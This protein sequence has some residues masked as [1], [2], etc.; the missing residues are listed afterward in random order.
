[1][2]RIL[3]IAFFSLILVSCNR[4]PSNNGTNNSNYRHAIKENLLTNDSFKDWQLSKYT[5]GT[6]VY[7]IKPCALDDITRFKKAGGLE[8]WE[9]AIQCN[10]QDA[11]MRDTYWDF[12]SNDTLII[13]GGTKWTLDELTVNSLRMSDNAI[14]EITIIY[15]A[16]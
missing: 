10:S 2:K 4:E 5:F 1:M 15:T 3:F 8:F 6:E 13:I 12:P 11:E 7:T 16:K 14:P 9:G